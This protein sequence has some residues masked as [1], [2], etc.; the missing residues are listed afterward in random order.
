MS[1]E[2]PLTYMDS[3]RVSG[4]Y[5]RQVITAAFFCPAFVHEIAAQIDNVLKQYSSLIPADALQFAVPSATSGVWRRL[6]SATMLRCRKS[7]SGEGAS[8]RPLTFFHFSD[9]EGC[10]SLHSFIVSGRPTDTASESARTLVQMTFGIEVAG[11]G[12]ADGFV[13][14]LLSMAAQLPWS[15]GYC[16]PSFTVSELDKIKAW[17]ALRPVALRF[18]GYDVQDN[19]ESALTIGDRVRGAR[20]LTFVGKRPLE[21]LGGMESL[22]ACLGDDVVVTVAGEGVMIRAGRT[23]EVGDRNRATGT[24]SMRVVARAVEPV[25]Y[26]GEPIVLINMMRGDTTALQQWERRF[27]DQ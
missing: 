9:C 18:P 3:A 11:E 16:G 23:P 24:P 8:K 10:A 20:W 27:I 1:L 4:P 5:L 17:A 26:F 15:G 2:K 12:H 19:V 6:D 25:T 14:A 13:E 21:M 7:L 22:R